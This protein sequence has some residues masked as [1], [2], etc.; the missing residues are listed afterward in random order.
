MTGWKAPFQIKRRNTWG[1]TVRM[2]FD[3]ADFINSHGAEPKGRGGWAFSVTMAD[4]G[5]GEDDVFFAPSGTY[6]Q[7][8][9]M[10]FRHFAEKYPTATELFVTVLPYKWRES[11]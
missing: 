4:E 8:R 6:T 2:Q 10:A 11:K 9:E 1:L 3:V 5:P 7:A